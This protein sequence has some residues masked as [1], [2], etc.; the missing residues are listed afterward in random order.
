MRPA[1]LLLSLLLPLVLACGRPSTMEQFIKAEDAAASAVSP[2]GVDRFEV[3]FFDSLATYD[4]S[5]Y[6]RL[7]DTG[8]RNRVHGSEPL[9]LDVR[10]ISPAKETA[11]EE[12][13]YIPYGG[14]RGV[15]E[16]YRS[17]VKPGSAGVWTIELRP[18]AE[19]LLP[20][21]GIGIICVC[22]GTR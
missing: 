4:I 2:G 12:R 13:V 20:I 8:A 1:P 19:N 6:T 15:K 5:L 21:S 9:G 14:I 7:A 22:N 16:L 17:G 18:V 3:D 10:W 11:L